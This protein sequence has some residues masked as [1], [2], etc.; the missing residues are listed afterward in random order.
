[1]LREKASAAAMLLLQRHPLG[2]AASSSYFLVDRRPEVTALRKDYLS[3]TGYRL[4]TEAEWE[5]ACRAGAV[6][7]R[8]YG[9]TEELLA[10]YGR[11]LKNS[12][13]RTWPV[14]SR[15]PNDLGLF[16]MHGNVYSWCQET[17][18]G[19]YPTTKSEE[20]IE[21]KEDICTIN[22]QKSRVLRG[23]SFSDR[24]SLVR[25]AHRGRDV[26]TDRALDVGFRPARTHR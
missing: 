25:S 20:I 23:G 17:Y 15:M 22:V 24:A 19:D 9:E 10:R 2:A 18:L 13:E 26:P 1:L 14:G 3:L 4:P 21:D 7:S 16:D 11:Y 8:H 6:T 12:G 5:Y